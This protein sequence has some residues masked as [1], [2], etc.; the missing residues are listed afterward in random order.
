MGDLIAIK[1]KICQL[2]SGL[3]R[4]RMKDNTT[5]GKREKKSRWRA[6]TTPR[7]AQSTPFLLLLQRRAPTIEP[8]I[9]FGESARAQV[10][11]LCT[12]VNKNELDMGLFAHQSVYKHLLGIYSDTDNDD[13]V[14]KVHIKSDVV[15]FTDIDPGDFDRLDVHHL[16][17][18][19]DFIAQGYN[20][21]L[22]SLSG[23]HCHFADC[24]G[25]QIYLHNYNLLAQE[26]DEIKSKVKVSLNDAFGETTSNND[27]KTKNAEML[28][29]TKSKKLQ[30]SEVTW[31]VA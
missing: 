10:A 16:K 24:Y 7:N 4:K 22:R 29:S 20:K 26:H 8:S 6:V 9:V 21:V 14:A 17:Q 1:C 12:M 18:L 25:E 5:N 19:L 23:D 30:G 11:I 13:D 3:G 15:L 2:Y 27:I 31:I 28:S